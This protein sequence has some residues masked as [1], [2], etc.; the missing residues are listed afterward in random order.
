MEAAGDLAN[1]GTSGIL[2]QVV[3]RLKHQALVALARHRTKILLAFFKD[4]V[5]LPSRRPG[6]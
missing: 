4:V 3:E 1:G 5:E 2:E 6:E